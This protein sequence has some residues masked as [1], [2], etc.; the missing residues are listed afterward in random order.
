MQ[1][2]GKNLKIWEFAA[3]L[4]LLTSMITLVSLNNTPINDT[5][6]IMMKQPK[7]KHPQNDQKYY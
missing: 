3:R 2:L 5:S 6:P 7:I 1:R 4:S